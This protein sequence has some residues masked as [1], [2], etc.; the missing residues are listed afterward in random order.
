[1]PLSKSDER[2]QENPF[3]VNYLHEAHTHKI[4]THNLSSGARRENILCHASVCR[5]KSHVKAG[6]F[7][8][9]FQLVASQVDTVT[10]RKT[11]KRV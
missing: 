3:A 6:K 1:M 4:V 7:N 5:M 2:M 11:F 8:L 9:F 10:S